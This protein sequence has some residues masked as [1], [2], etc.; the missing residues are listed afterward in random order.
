MA[1]RIF[2]RLSVVLFFIS[3]PLTA[4][5][6]GTESV[7]GFKALIYGWV[8]IR[9]FSGVPWL[10][11]PL[12]L[13]TWFLFFS[14]KLEARRNAVFT[15]AAAFL[16]SLSFLLV[17][18]IPPISPGM[19]AAA[20]SAKV[21]YWLWLAS[22]VS[23]FVSAILNLPNLRKANYKTGRAVPGR[24]SAKLIPIRYDDRRSLNKLDSCFLS[25]EQADLLH[26]VNGT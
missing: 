5:I 13:F 20:V 1:K 17:R 9:R 8:G 23:L 21:G 18:E 11:N 10:A 24:L 19:K 14:P 3:L 26:Q 4:F 7:S 6:M 16:L 12:C 22:M 15:S 25:P 2:R